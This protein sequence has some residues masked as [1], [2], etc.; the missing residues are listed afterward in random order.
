[1]SRI[2]ITFDEVAS[3]AE[4]ILSQG[5]SPTIDKVRAYL[6]GTGSNSTIS[7]YLNDWRNHY[8]H[9]AHSAASLSQKI[10]TPAPLNSAMER[11]WQEMNAQADAK[12]NAMKEKMAVN[13]KEAEQ[14]FQLVCDERD[15]LNEQ[16]A[17]L[18]G[19]HREMA[20]NHEIVTLDI[21]TLREERQLLQ[22]HHKNLEERYADLHRMTS[23]HLRE[24]S[25]AHKSEITRLSE[26]IKLAEHAHRQL[27]D[28]LNKEREH[29]RQ[30][31][32]S[33][34]DGLR[35]ENKKKTGIIEKIQVT[36]QEQK[37]KQAEMK[38]MIENLIRERDELTQ[39]ITMQENKWN[40]I[41]PL[42]EKNTR[43][44]EEIFS[45]VKSLSATNVDLNLSYVGIFQNYDNIL[46][47][48]LLK[49]NDITDRLSATVGLTLTKNGWDQKHEG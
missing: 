9:S 11:L 40:C 21:K 18:L 10:A 49:V 32:I 47:E 7:K 19:Q 6:G 44:T 28:A 46:K 24:L 39:R 33:S 37:T 20:A 4:F 2:G 48:S 15:T 27:I 29:E 25:D 36:L 23:Q 35:M 41:N 12:L 16:Y 1:M 26:N 8:F 13:A 42:I 43:V 22:I 38:L 17:A 31:Y 34:L 45:N 14:K 5:A 3:A 30:Q